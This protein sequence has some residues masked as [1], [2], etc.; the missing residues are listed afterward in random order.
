MILLAGVM[1]KFMCPIRSGIENDPRINL[2]VDPNL[3]SRVEQEMQGLLTWSHI[4]MSH[5]LLIKIMR[6]GGP[7]WMF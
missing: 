7:G 2:A 6:V 4:Y 1:Y 3:K 5:D